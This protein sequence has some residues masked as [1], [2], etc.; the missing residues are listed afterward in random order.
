MDLINSLKTALLGSAVLTII[1]PP[2]LNWAL[3]FFGCSGDD[4]LTKDIVEV[5]ACSGGS[6][7]SIPY[8]LQKTVGGV[9]AAV[10]LILTGYFKGGTLKQNL[11]NKSVPQ[12][13]AAEAK[14]GVVTAT[15]VASEKP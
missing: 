3:T 6:L 2:V 13:P 11:L 1:G 7:I 8:W 4:P 9:V 5:A 12:V 15:Q 14:P 10:V